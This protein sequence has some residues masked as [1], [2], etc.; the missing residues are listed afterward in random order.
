MSQALATQ[1]KHSIFGEFGKKYGVSPEKVSDLLK[2]TAFKLPA[3]KNDNG[4]ETQIVTDEQMA[5]LLI[6][7]NQFG[8]NPFTREIYAFP[9]KKGG[10][11]TPIVGIDGWMRI[12]NEHPQFDGMEFR[13]AEKAINV[14]EHAKPCPE[15]IEVVIY[16]KDR[17]RPTVIREYIE[18]C[19]V[20]PYKGT[21]RNGEYLTKGPWQSHTK[22]QLRHKALMQGARIAFGFAGVYDEDEGK[23]I[24][25]ARLIEVEH[26]A[27]S[28]P[29]DIT[30]TQM[31]AL[32]SAQE[33]YIVM[34]QGMGFKESDCDSYLDAW[35]AHVKS[36]KDEVKRIAV[37]SPNE[38][39]K[40][41]SAYENSRIAQQNI[42]QNQTPQNHAPQEQAIQ[43]TAQAETIPTLTPQAE[44]MSTLESQSIPD[45]QTNTI[46][47]A[48]LRKKAIA[49]SQ[50][51]GIDN[52]YSCNPEKWT[53]AQCNSVIERATK[54]ITDFKDAVKQDEQ[55][56]LL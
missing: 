17:T 10:G 8:L 39:Y 3:K 31:Q 7:A 54:A 38:F 36:S 6:V 35:S 22:R 51:S 1:S 12:C 49:L 34:I 24:A 5:A 18:E 33:Q 52:P 43:A 47:L 20:A 15:Y 48:E 37:T 16:R 19:Y 32:P 30:P 26:G 25:E 46:P 40:S 2:A 11:I 29:I 42:Q 53:T 27:M 45:S 14:D 21:G 55:Q 56:S 13:Y 28:V 4:Y 23:R 44:G 50:E 41:F 9:D